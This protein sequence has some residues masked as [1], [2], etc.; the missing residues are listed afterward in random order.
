MR[1]SG[2]IIDN[3]GLLPGVNIVLLSSN[4]TPTTIGTITDAN[5]NFSLDKPEIKPNSLIQISFIGYYTVLIVASELQGLTI[6][7][8]ENETILDGITIYG[9]ASKNKWL[10]WLIPIAAGVTYLISKGAKQPIVQPK[11]VKI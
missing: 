2:K 1:I 7:L 11:R 8:Q 5:G 3:N 6:N 9:G 10:L 4:N